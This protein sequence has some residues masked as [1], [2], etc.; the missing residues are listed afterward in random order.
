LKFEGKEPLY[1]R[2]EELYQDTQDIA[3]ILLDAEVKLGEMLE[4]IDKS[5]S[6]L[7]GSTKGTTVKS[8]LPSGITKKQS[9]EAQEI[10]RRGGN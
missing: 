4:K 8:T 1:T 9:H 2:V 3:D 5:D 10:A 7:R 6:R